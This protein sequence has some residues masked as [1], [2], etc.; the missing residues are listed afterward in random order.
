MRGYRKC[1]GEDTVK[2]LEEDIREDTGEVTGKD[3]EEDR[4]KDIEMM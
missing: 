1:I 4:G 3:I 2:H